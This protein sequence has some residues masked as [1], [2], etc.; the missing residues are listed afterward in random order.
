MLSK[1]SIRNFATPAFGNF[2][3]KKIDFSSLHSVLPNQFTNNLPFNNSFGRFF[4]Q[5]NSKSKIDVLK[6]KADSGDSE[7]Q[8]ELG[9]YYLSPEKNGTVDNEKGVHYIKLAAENN[10]PTACYMYGMY[11]KNG[12]HVQ[13]DFDQALKYLTY[14]ADHNLEVAQFE[15]ALEYYTGKR[16]PVDL[17]KSF[18]Y[19]CLSAENGNVT[20]CETAGTFLVQGIGCKPDIKQAIKYFT[21]GSDLNSALCKYQLSIIYRIDDQKKSIQFLKESANSGFLIA[22]QEYSKYLLYSEKNEKEAVKYLRLAS[23]QNDADSCL[24]LSD[25]LKRSN[26]SI[27]K[28]EA[29]LLLKK[30]AS[31][32]NNTAMFRVGKIYSGNPDRSYDVQVEKDINLAAKYLKKLADKGNDPEYII[33]YAKLLSLNLIDQSKSSAASSKHNEKDIDKMFNDGIKLAIR[34]GCL[35]TQYIIDYYDF[36]MRSGQNQFAIVLLRSFRNIKDPSLLYRLAITRTKVDERSLFQKKICMEKTFS[37]MFKVTEFDIKFTHIDDFQHENDYLNRLNNNLQKDPNDAESKFLLSLA[38]LFGIGM[39]QPD[40]N[41]GLD[42]MK[43]I[44]ESGNKIAMKI[45]PTWMFLNIDGHLKEKSDLESALSICKKA[46]DE[47]NDSVCQFWYGKLKV[48]GDFFVDINPEEGLK[49]LEK[50]AAANNCEALYELGV[51]YMGGIAVKADR[52]KA[53]E[54]FNQAHLFGHP[55]AMES[56]NRLKNSH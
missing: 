54:Y 52:E 51:L 28:R 17:S 16:Y 40:V 47:N 55:K 49:Y 2:I 4:S 32:G 27:E 31:L 48:Y 37:Y 45:Y 44:A 18:H 1:I 21:L 39:N 26:N 22:Q 33:E 46:A 14:A 30:A 56:L 5:T 35:K 41:E 11:L 24:E 43:Q 13:K 7:A 34:L 10:H 20:S 12:F 25:I 3:P 53:K 19:F 38:N 6:E 9:S 15:L 36:F 29:F 42:M 23:N 8:Y 50:A